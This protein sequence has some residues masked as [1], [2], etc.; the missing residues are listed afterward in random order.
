VLRTVG[1]A[2][3]NEVRHALAR[4]V[5]E[6]ARTDQARFGT[7]NQLETNKIGNRSYA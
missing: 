7:V 4:V 6:N 2:R 3:L 5:R 1:L